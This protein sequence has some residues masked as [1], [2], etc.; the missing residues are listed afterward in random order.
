MI[1][2]GRVASSFRGHAGRRVEYR[3]DAHPPNNDVSPSP[4]EILLAEDLQRR[5][6]EAAAEIERRTKRLL[7]KEGGAK[8]TDQAADRVG[9]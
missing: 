1:A 3:V 8:P 5:L 7:A 4:L 9:S 2:F 6:R